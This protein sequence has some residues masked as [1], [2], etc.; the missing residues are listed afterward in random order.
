MVKENLENVLKRIQNAAIRCG[1]APDSIRLVAVTKT[2]PAHRIIEAVAAGANIFGENYVQEAREKILELSKL[3]VSWHFIG[4]LQ[5]NK[6]KY[7][8]KLFDLIHSVDSV[9]LAMEIDKQARKIS[10][11]QKILIQINVAGEIQKSGIFPEQALDMLKDISSFENISVKGLMTMPPYFY[12]PEKVRPFFKQLRELRD[13][14]QKEV[15]QLDYSGDILLDDLSMGM[16]GDFEVAIEEG[17]T[18]VR[19]GTAIFGER[20]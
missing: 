11:I 4:T 6:A 14:L 18:F 9:K 10:K 5:S 15:V 3:P 8:V 20:A 16:T 1:R 12:N 19:I 7:V 13:R 2:V 17:A